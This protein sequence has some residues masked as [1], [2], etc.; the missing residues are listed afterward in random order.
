MSLKL[1]NDRKERKPYKTNTFETFSSRQC[2]NHLL[3]LP[4]RK[5]ALGKTSLFDRF[6]PAEMESHLFG[7]AR[8]RNHFEMNIH[9]KTLASK[10]QNEPQCQNMKLKIV[11]M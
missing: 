6:D 5:K 9:F 11:K 4:S 2:G 10:C 1:S 8:K 3:T 7:N